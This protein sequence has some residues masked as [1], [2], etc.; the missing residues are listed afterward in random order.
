MGCKEG[1]SLSLEETARHLK[2]YQQITVTSVWR[3]QTLL[4]NG[5]NLPL[6]IHFIKN[7]SFQDG[8]QNDAFCFGR[9]EIVL[10]KPR[11][12]LILGSIHL[13]RELLISVIP[14]LPVTEGTLAS[15]DTFLGPAS[16]FS[17]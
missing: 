9:L 7:C 17:C 1:N 11:P 2:S 4:P 6:L 12:I 14:F 3:E 10:P 15:L 5:M 8:K 13:H 16:T